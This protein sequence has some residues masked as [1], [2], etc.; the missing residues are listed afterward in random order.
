MAAG[1]SRNTTVARDC[2]T[3]EAAEENDKLVYGISTRYE[4]R[5]IMPSYIDD[6]VLGK[7]IK[8]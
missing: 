5:G 2:S 8:R 7:T 3:I 4:V 6:G 1:V